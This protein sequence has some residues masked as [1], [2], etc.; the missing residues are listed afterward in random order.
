MPH[1][2]VEYSANLESHCDVARLCEA[3][4]VAGLETGV[5]PL[6]GIRVRAARCTDYAIAD[7]DPANIFVDISIRLRGGRP[8][9]AKEAATAHVFEAAR[10]FLAPVI[11]TQPIML[12]LEMRDIDPAL[13]PKLNTVRDHIAAKDAK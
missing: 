7:G 8:Q 13:S 9:E 11:E 10:A 6:A 2:R 5:F 4:R 1:I 12:S 3:L